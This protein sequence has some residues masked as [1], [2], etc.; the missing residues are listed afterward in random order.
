MIRRHFWKIEKNRFF[1]PKNFGDQ[2][3]PTQKLPFWVQKGIKNY[4][5]MIPYICKL[6]SNNILVIKS[7]SFCLQLKFCVPTSKTQKSTFSFNYRFG[8]KK[9]CKIQKFLNFWNPQNLSF[10]SIY[11]FM[12]VSP[13]GKKIYAFVFPPMA[14]SWPLAGSFTCVIYNYNYLHWAFCV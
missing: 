8:Y 10:L 6:F 14:W 11:T 13:I 7:H 2:H 5:I 1:D 3:P 12:G 9:A 4:K